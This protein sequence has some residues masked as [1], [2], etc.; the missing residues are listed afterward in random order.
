MMKRTLLLAA[1]FAVGSM[2]FVSAQDAVPAASTDSR[3]YTKEMGY[4]RIVTLDDRIKNQRLRI[5]KGLTSGTLTA[6]QAAACGAIL[7]S[8][9]NQMKAEYAAN[10]PRK[11]MTR[12]NYDAY[13]TTLDANSSVIHEQK[14]YFYYYGPYADQGPDYDYYYDAY[15]AAGA[16]TPSVSDLAKAN[17]RMFELKDRL[18]G[19]R[20]RI[21]GDLDAKTLTEDQAKNCN[22]VLDSVEDQ[23]KTDFTANGSHKLTRD[24]YA[25]LNAMLDANS[26]LIQ[27]SRQYYYYYNNPKFDPNYDQTY[28]N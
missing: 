13:N 9:D 1:V 7:D 27:E 24:Q 4:V 14:Q 19:Q 26:T 6:D 5:A 15:A 25:G 23:I 22:G 8:M 11:I 21:Q 16:P 20:A 12:D 3:S 10:G 28:T 18:A 17:P 2:G